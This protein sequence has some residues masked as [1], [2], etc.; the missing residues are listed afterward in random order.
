LCKLVERAG[1]DKPQHR[2]VGRPRRRLV[3]RRPA[4]VRTGQ[5]RLLVL[6][7]GDAARAWPVA[8]AVLVVSCPC[9][10]SLATPPRWPPPPAACCGR[11]Y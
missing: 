10:L 5:F 2:A 11:A 1:S 9:A 6:V 8:I 4:A 7:D 3:R